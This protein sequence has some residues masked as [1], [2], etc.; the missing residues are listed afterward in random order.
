MKFSKGAGVRIAVA[1]AGGLLL[2]GTASAAFAAEVG[3]HDVDVN[4]EI[5]PVTSPGSLSLTVAGT[6]STLTEAASGDPEVRRFDGTLP[7]VTVTDTREVAEIPAGHFW[8][9][10]GQ[11]SAFTGPNGA[12]ISPDHL[13]WTPSLVDGGDTGV[14]AEGDA[15][16]TSEDA[17]ANAV[18][19][20]DKELLYGALESA[21]VKAGGETSWAATAALVLKTEVDVI[22]GA[23]AAK[24]TLS[25]FEDAQ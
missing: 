21:A 10:V 3:D 25:L 20:V 16:G 5:A 11:A 14:V 4:V 12:S 1:A 6:S 19:L 8:Y 23:Y 24:L 15:V 17:G 9:V 18:G 7:T 2:V 22:P 13:G